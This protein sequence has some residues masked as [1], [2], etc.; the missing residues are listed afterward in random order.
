VRG[1]IITIALLSG[2]TVWYIKPLVTPV[3]VMD[4]AKQIE[5]PRISLEPLAPIYDIGLSEEWAKI[6]WE[7][8]Q[9]R[10]VE[11]EL[12]L[13]VMMTENRG[14]NPSLISVTN[15]YGLFQ[16]NRVNHKRM[17]NLGYTDMLDAS[18]NIRAGIYI[19]AECL[20]SSDSYTEALM[21]YNMGR[22]GANKAMARGIY[23]TRYSDK[24]MSHYNDL[25]GDVYGKI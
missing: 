15:D 6:V 14:F 16:V 12:A 3:V 20:N 17:A 21:A 25:K 4:M 2:F 24:V 18:D 10:E 9:A 23:S 11:Y 5:V 8:C 7:E 19:L 1:L 13:A 22:G